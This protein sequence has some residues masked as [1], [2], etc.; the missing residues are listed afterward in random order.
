MRYKNQ[1]EI[2]KTQD[3]LLNNYYANTPDKHPDELTK[4]YIYKHSKRFL[5]SLELLPDSVVK[6]GAKILEIGAMPYCFSTLLI[7]RFNVE[8]SALNLPNTIFPG[9]PYKI[10][11]ETIIIPNK[12]T[13]KQYKIKSWICNAEKDIYPYDDNIFDVVICTEVIEHLLYSPM[14]LFQESQR[15]L[16][17]DG[18]MLVSTVNALYYKRMVDIILNNNIDDVFTTLGCYGRHSRNWTQREL[19]ELANNSNFDVDYVTSATLRGTRSIYGTASA[20]AP[21]LERNI[22]KPTYLSQVAKSLRKLFLNLVKVLVFLPLP[23]MRNKRY[24]NIFL[25]LRKN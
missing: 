2:K 22:T 24:S 16:R 18:L 15:V 17:K 11:N 6:P 13:Q 5:F 8:V 23:G 10:T 20:I 14:H 3:F 7:E 19:I 25:L 1:S 12:Q 21:M 4:K 9:E